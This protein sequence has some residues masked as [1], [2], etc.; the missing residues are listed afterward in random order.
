MSAP[1]CGNAPV[2]RGVGVAAQH[3]N[4][5]SKIATDPREIQGIRTRRNRDQRAPAWPAPRGSVAAGDLG[6]ALAGWTAML[7]R[8][9]IDP[10]AKRGRS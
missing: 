10:M 4:F 6:R 8:E 1:R 3:E 9:P 7:G 5:G 2:A